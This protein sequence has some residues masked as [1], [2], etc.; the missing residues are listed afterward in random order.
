MQSRTS[1]F[2]GNADNR[3]KLRYYKVDSVLITRNKYERYSKRIFP[4]QY[5]DW[6]YE[7]LKSSGQTAIDKKE[8]RMNFETT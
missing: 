7:C 2:N 4:K 1:E 8:Q 3:P 6:S 5:W